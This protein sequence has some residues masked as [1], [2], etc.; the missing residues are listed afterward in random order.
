M[1]NEQTKIIPENFIDLAVNTMSFQEM[2]IVDIQ[3]YFKLLRRILKQENLFY[4]VN[5]VEKVMKFNGRDMPIRFFDF[6]W[7][8]NDHDYKYVLSNV[9]IGRTYKPFFVKAAKL[10]KDIK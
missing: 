9:E 1:T 6:P 8:K 5:A 2:R 3:N 10:N 7:S 4:C